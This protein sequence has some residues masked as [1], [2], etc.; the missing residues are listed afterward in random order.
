MSCGYFAQVL[1]SAVPDPALIEGAFGRALLCRDARLFKAEGCPVHG[2]FCALAGQGSRCVVEPAR[3]VPSWNSSRWSGNHPLAS[4]RSQ[5]FP[6]GEAIRAVSHQLQERAVFFEPLAG[7]FLP[8]FN[9]QKD[10]LPETLNAFLLGSALPVCLRN[11]RTKGNKPFA[12]TMDF[13]GQRNIH[14]LN[15]AWH[16]VNA[17]ERQSGETLGSGT[18]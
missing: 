10:R 8:I 17:Q 2:K 5:R 16:L 3:A 15:M 18:D 7:V 12:L 4:I 1:L 13:G 6:G 9:Q 11:L 14:G